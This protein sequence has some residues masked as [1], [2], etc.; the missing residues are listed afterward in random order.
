[1]SDIERIIESIDC[2]DECEIMEFDFDECFTALR[3]MEYKLKNSTP[4]AKIQEII[5]S[6]DGLNID[7][8][9]TERCRDEI[10]GSLKLLIGVNDAAT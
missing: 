10:I 2:A 7:C 6:Y 9:E 5:N 8:V 3:E 1:M 4:N